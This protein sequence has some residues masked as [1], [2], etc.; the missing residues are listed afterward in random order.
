[1]EMNNSRRTPFRSRRERD[2]DNIRLGISQ[3]DVNGIGYEVLL[4]CFSDTRMFE[5]CTPIL[6][7]SSKVASY[8]KKLINATDFPFV[9]IRTVEQAETSKFNILNIIQDEVN[10]I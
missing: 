1:M 5:N 6:Y 2:N 4:K 3:G 9:N 10:W 8:H 7:G